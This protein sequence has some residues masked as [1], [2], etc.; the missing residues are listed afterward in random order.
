MGWVIILGLMPV[1]VFA[2]NVGIGRVASNIMDPVSVVSDFVHSGCILIGGAFI[3]ASIVK[4][5]E[6]R[7]N[8][9]MVPIST[10]IFLLIAGF[11]LVCLPFISYVTANGVPYT[12]LQ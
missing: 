5:I 1:F 10:V 7:K 2:A 4:Y 8:P 6:H 9:L 11:V 12:L 3:F